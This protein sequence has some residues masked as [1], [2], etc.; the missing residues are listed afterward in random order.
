MLG[1]GKPPKLSGE[2]E[3]ARV[4]RQR[5]TALG[6]KVA[7]CAIAVLAGCSNVVT[8]SEAPAGSTL[9]FVTFERYEP[10]SAAPSQ[11][12]ALPEGGAATGTGTRMY[13]SA[14]FIRLQ[15]GADEKLAARL[16]GAGLTL[17]EAGHCDVSP[18]L[19]DEGIP[20]ASLGPVDLVDV[21]EINVQAGEARATLAPRAFPDLVD[22]VSGVVY[23][24]R[25][26]ATASLPERGA[27]RV[28]VAGSLTF[29]PA[30]LTATAPGPVSGF[31]V[32]G[33][34]PENGSL[35][36]APG[37]VT[38]AWDPAAGEASLADVV[39]VELA[40][41]NDPSAR[42][43]RCTFA[44]TGHGVLSGESLPTWADWSLRVH[45][46]HREPLVAAAIDGGE[47]RFD[48]ATTVNLHFAVEG[49]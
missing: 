12:A 22:L 39:Y 45:R 23:T 20:L 19:Q 28:E 21:G 35:S 40:P 4:V 14:Y 2:M 33:V 6:A 30:T 36:V 31:S 38:L 15:A 10:A 34:K 29:L 37:D 47:I 48:E 1:F 27:Y 7:P 16:V 44:D 9:A 17:P 49:P 46:V 8:T 3:G 25:E 32:D 43:T 26:S 11:P 24:T 18:S 41:L 5:A 13:A 42:H